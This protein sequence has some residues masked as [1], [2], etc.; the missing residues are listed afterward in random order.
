MIGMAKRIVPWS[1]MRYAITMIDKSVLE[2]RD[3]W[4]WG[5]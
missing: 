1:G 2:A 3:S 4:P 5:L